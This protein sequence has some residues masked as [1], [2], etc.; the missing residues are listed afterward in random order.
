MRAVGINLR[1]IDG[2]EK[3]SG[4]TIYA[5]D[6]RLPGMVCAKV[7]R[8][9][10]AHARI[11]R[12]ETA[13]AAALPGVLAILT[14][15]NLDVASNSFG[16]YVRDQQILAT[17]KV[18][19]A[20]DMV[21]AIAASDPSIAEQATQLI[22][23][24]YDELPAVFGVAEALREGAPLVH[25]SLQGRKDPGYGRGGTHIVHHNSNICFHFRHQR[26]DITEGFA[27]ADRVFED[28]LSTETSTG[29]SGWNPKSK[30]QKPK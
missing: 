25:E 23:A 6:L 9:P 19:Y 14:R 16:A 26:S 27:S 3:V 15:E 12:V 1:R 18:R 24:D 29:S 28:T 8:S 21:A 11:R 30:I 17:D 2:A 7:L 4:Q 5:G 22:E 10:L 20:G 13:K